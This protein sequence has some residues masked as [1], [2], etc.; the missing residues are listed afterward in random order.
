MKR[1]LALALAFVG[2]VLV[3]AAAAIYLTGLLDTAPANSSVVA[4]P[5][6]P[7]SQKLVVGSGG[8]DASA[9][10]TSSAPIPIEDASELGADAGPRIYTVADDR[11]AVV[12][13]DSISG[14]ARA[15]AEIW[16]DQQFITANCMAEKGYP[17]EFM[18]WWDRGSQPGHDPKLNQSYGADEQLALWGDTG[19]GADYHWE[20]AGCVGYSVHVTGQDNNH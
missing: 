1:L 6:A 4:D 13:P 18:M 8:D 15:N 19:A 2:V 20:D 7:P 5:V 16:V 9:S 17:F 10:P 12:I 11:S 14:A 3:G